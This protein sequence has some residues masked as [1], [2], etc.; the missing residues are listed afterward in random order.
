MFKRKRDKNVDPIA[1]KHTQCACIIYM[2][3]FSNA[4][5]TA[6]EKLPYISISSGIAI[7]TKQVQPLITMITYARS[8]LPDPCRGVSKG[9]LRVHEHPLNFQSGDFPIQ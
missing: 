6:A 7:S 8:V 9:V 5:D 1:P 4:N 2:P 3:P